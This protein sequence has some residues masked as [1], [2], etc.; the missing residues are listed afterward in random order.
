MISAIIKVEVSVT[1]RCEPKAEADN[2]NRDLD[3]SD[4]TK[5]ESND[6][7]IA[8][9]FEMNNNR[10]TVARNRFEVLSEIMHCACILQINQLSASI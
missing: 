6:C 8:H 3:Y 9:C 7:F 2:T 5:T 10:H 1:S 4:I